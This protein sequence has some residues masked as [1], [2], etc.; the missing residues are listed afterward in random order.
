MKFKRFIS[1][2]LLCT[3]CL[4]MLKFLEYNHSCTF[5]EYESASILVKRQRAFLRVR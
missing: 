3:S 5:T 2:F 1:V 4:G